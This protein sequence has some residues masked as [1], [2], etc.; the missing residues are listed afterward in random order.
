MRIL[1]LIPA[2]GGS[3][4]IPGKNIRS[5]GGRPL[6][7]W[8]IDIIKGLPDIC[9][10][11]IST[12]DPSI[13]DVAVDAGALVP[14]LRPANLAN[15]TAS[16]TDVCLHALD[17]YESK[18]GQVDGLLL[19]QPTSPFRSRQT[20][21]RGIDL[22]RAHQGRPVISVSLADSHPMWCMQIDGDTMRPFMDSGALKFRSQ[23]IPPAYAVNGAFYII[24]P[25]DLRKIRTFFGG[26]MVP[27]VMDSPSECLDID[28]EW[29][30]N[31][32]EAI[33]AMKSNDPEC[34]R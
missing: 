5:L 27:L 24:Q 9:D 28:T 26:E 31:I 2:R 21:L 14:W 19:L 8:S 25:G 6:I 4:R 33:L 20:V 30:W 15:D 22:F 12:D 18:N 13:A 32:A 29:D 10:I 23:D 3:K 16:S 17:W 7:A 34:V 1:A 11:L